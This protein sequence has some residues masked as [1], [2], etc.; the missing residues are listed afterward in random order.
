MFQVFPLEGIGIGKH[1]GRFLERDAMI[2][3]IPGGF[4]S[5]P[6]EH[7]LCI[8]NNYH[9]P[10]K[11]EL[12]T[13]ADLCEL[14]GHLWKLDSFDWLTSILAGSIKILTRAGS[15]ACATKAGTIRAQE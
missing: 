15:T 7:N 13:S 6:G 5:I 12:N 9:G 3:K 11:G 4:S 1:G 2:F 14:C 8:Y 10:V